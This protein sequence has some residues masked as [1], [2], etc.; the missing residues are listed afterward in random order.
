M[1]IRT[2]HYIGI[3]IGGTHFRIGT[4]SQNGIVRNFEKISSKS[5]FLE[6]DAIP[7]LI[8]YINCYINRFGLCDGLAAISIGFPSPISKDKRIVYN[9]PN[10]QSING[11]FDGKDVV[12]PIQNALCVPVYIAKDAVFILQH[13]LVKYKLEDKG[14]VIGI[15]FGTGIGN[16]VY[17]N[18]SFIDGKHGVA[19]DLGH[20]PFYESDKYC[21]CGNRGCAECHASGRALEALWMSEFIDTPFSELFIHHKDSDIIRSFIEAMSIPI[22]TEINIFDPDYVV[23]GGGVLEMKDFP[24]EK[25]ISCVS[26]FVR[27]PYPGD[28]FEYIK[29]S[30]ADNI[31]VIGGAYYA[32]KQMN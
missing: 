25:L 12:T 17:I 10:L 23:L 21:T 6:K 31:G 29:A 28:D 11:G 4:V 26:E 22:A 20:I 24:Y 1:D 30:N 15:Y 14:I 13:D 3:D 16:I 19:C 18:D 27:R 7:A 9:C 8:E 5:L 2:K 32:M